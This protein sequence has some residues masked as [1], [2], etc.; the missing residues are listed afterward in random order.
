MQ[1]VAS[2]ESKRK[3]RK[4]VE[5]IRR[6]S[7]RGRRDWNGVEAQRRRV[8]SGNRE[9]VEGSRRGGEFDRLQTIKLERAT[10]GDDRSFC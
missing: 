5:K 3:E 2:S 6:M 7:R 8:S 10:E 1:C 9:F 4:T